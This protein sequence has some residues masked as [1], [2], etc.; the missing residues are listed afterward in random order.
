METGRRTLSEE[1]VSVAEALGAAC[2]QVRPLGAP[3][4]INI[5]V[6]LVSCA[7]QY[8]LADRQRLHQVLLNLLSNATK[9]NCEGGSVTV[10][11][12]SRTAGRVR[13]GIRDTGPGIPSD[14][15]PKLFTPFERLAAAE[16]GIEGTGLGLSVSKSFI[17]AMHGSIGVETTV[18]AGS[19]FWIDLRAAAI[20]ASEPEPDPGYG[21]YCRSDCSSAGTILYIED[22]LV[23]LDLVTQMIARFTKLELLSATRG[24]AGLRMARERR[25]DMI[26][27]D[28]HLPDLSGASVLQALM[29]AAET[30]DIPVVMLTADATPGQA[31]ALLAA[32]ARRYLTKPLD[33]GQLVEVITELLPSGEPIYV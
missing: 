33:F 10:T 30:R 2:D 28:L 6:D 16:S 4:D 21:G 3:R 14:G 7:G 12:Q 17:E 13:I 26:L 8:V 23:N 9:Y 18:G 5:R 19:T 1:P 20:P 11:C 25:P 31:E 15:L 32:G 22:N 27:L 29:A 24:E